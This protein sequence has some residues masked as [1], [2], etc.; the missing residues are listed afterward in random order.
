MSYTIIPGGHVTSPQGFLAASVHTGVKKD[1]DDLV[2]LLSETPTASTAVFTQNLAAAAPV[3]ISREVFSGQKV[4][5]V[6]INSGN[7]NACTGHKGMED[8]RLTQQKTAEA[9]GLS[10]GQVALASTGVIGLPLSMEKILAGIPAAV[11]ALTREG[12]ASAAEGIMTT[13]TRRKTIAVTTII[14]GKTVTIG[15]MAKGSGM[16]NP[17]MATMLGFVTTDAVVEPNFLQEAFKE[18]VAD[19]YN[20]ITVDGD[21]STNDTVM[22]LA[23]GKAGNQP[24]NEKHPEKEAFLEAL[25]EV[26]KALAVSI[27]EDGEGAT[28]LIEAVTEGFAT[29]EDARMAAKAVLNSNLVKTAIFGEDGNWGRIICSLGYSGAAFS[30]DQVALEL[31][32]SKGQ[33]VKVLQEGLP[34]D[35]DEANVAEVLKDTHIM[36]HITAGAGEAAARGWGCDLSY[37]YVKIN[38]S[39]R[40]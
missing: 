18:V 6:L 11:S 13:D 28:K 9:L 19:T 5:A 22:V 35:Y 26:N 21:T 40:S 2:I 3:Q 39:Y 8:A 20:M 37:D 15:G 4:R 23:G 12:G 34:L 36:I 25:F 31:G 1:K 38:G 7:A 32:N 30:L 10:P 16:I 27:V 24:I 29:K 17:N 14:D 33:R